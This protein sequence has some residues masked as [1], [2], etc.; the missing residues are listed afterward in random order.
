MNIIGARIDGRLVHGQVANL[1]IPK[2]H[3]DRVVVVDDNVSTSEIEKSGLRLATPMGVK[4]SAL[5]VE[6]AAE[7]L[8]D[9]R[10]GEQRLFIIAK[11]PAPLAKLVELGVALKEINVGN[12]SKNDQTQALTNSVNIT[13]EDFEQFN[14]LTDQ[15]VKL[16]SQMVPGTKEESF[17]EI[18]KKFNQEVK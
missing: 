10:Y 12:M 6:E 15:Q 7:R 4:L 3:I 11:G 2:L 9:D 16:V 1:W 18:M 5:S 13:Q 8:N 14:F 17:V